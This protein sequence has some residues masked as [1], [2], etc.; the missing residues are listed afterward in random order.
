M[1]I[2]DARHAL[3]L[4]HVPAQGLA[5]ALAHAVEVAGVDRKVRADLHVA[6]VAADGVDAAGEHDPPHANTAWRRRRRCTCRRCWSA[7]GCPTSRS[8]PT[9]RR[10]GAGPRPC[11]RHVLRLVRARSVTSPTTTSP[12]GESHEASPSRS[13]TSRRSSWRPLVVL[14]EVAD[15]ILPGGPGDEDA[16]PCGRYAERARELREGLLLVVN[17]SPMR[18][19]CIRGSASRRNGRK[20]RVFRSAQQEASATRRTRCCP[21]R[22]RG[23]GG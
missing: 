18:R 2:G 11:R 21:R 8:G 20:F 9:G 3:L 19:G 22:I 7:A 12:K 5:E 4:G 6:G 13:W 15:P 23:R 10:P 16:E 1:R 17:E 14:G